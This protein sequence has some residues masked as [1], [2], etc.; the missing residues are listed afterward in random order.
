MLDSFKKYL[1]G[2]IPVQRVI[3]HDPR[4]E[5]TGLTQTI[6]ADRV[7]AFIREADG[8]NPRDLFALYTDILLGDAHIQTEL[9]KRKLAVLGDTVS[10]Q[11]VDEGNADDVAAAEAIKAMVADYEP[12]D[13]QDQEDFAEGAAEDFDYACAALLD[14]AIWPVV[15]MEKVFRASAKAGLNYDLADL[16]P[17]PAWLLD[18]STGKLRIRET[19]D[20]GLE[21][22][23]FIDPDR[24]RFIVHRGHLLTAPDYRGGPM[25]SLVMWSL[26]SQLGREWWARFLD[27]YGS[28]F[29]VGKYDQ[30]DDASRSVLERAFQ[31]AVRIGGLVVSKQ[32]EV[33]VLSASASQSGDAYEKFLAVCQRE[34][35][36]LILGQ[37][38][39]AES[40]PLGIGGGASDTHEG[41]RQDF[42]QFDALRL[43]KTLARQ[44][45]R[46]YLTINGFKGRVPTLT[47]GGESPMEATATGE[48]LS[49]LKTAG[50]RL[51]DDGIDDLSKR[52]G[53][54]LERD[55]AT[56]PGLPPKL[57]PALA[58]G[59]RLRL[60]STTPLLAADDA[61]GQIAA[62]AAAEL[63]QAFR[64]ALAPVRQMI[65][66]AESADDL[67]QRI[68]SAYADWSVGR[69]AGV[70]EAALVA[71]SLNAG[72]R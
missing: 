72:Q 53:L 62:N 33:E 35:S 5:T 58:L 15:V 71:F 28:P 23:T 2:L 60:L 34:K 32:T 8:A 64:G 21:T 55:Q 19:N 4:Q 12:L 14:G 17:V 11:P 37:T 10:I 43:G 42:R 49:K 20:T 3:V 25:R 63:S 27:R 39:S 59:A 41:V 22:G 30:A 50:I 26:L 24:R 13:A 67:Q 66:A 7:L 70:I 9:S 65:L 47:W 44:L 68:L 52:T 61:N 40:Q 1:A 48:L 38:L 57:P 6:S 29:L 46:Q 36:K 54:E 56:A 69:V 51:T 45:F 18:F 16:V 31:W